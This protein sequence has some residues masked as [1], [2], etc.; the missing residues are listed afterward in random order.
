MAFQIANNTSFID[1]S[2][3]NTNLDGTGT[4]TEFFQA[5]GTYGSVISSVR[6]QSAGAV[7]QGMVRIFIKNGV[8]GTWKLLKEVQIGQVPNNDPPY[9]VFGITL[10]TNLSLKN[11]YRLG[12]STQNAEHF[13]VTGFGYDITGFI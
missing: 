5:S 4:I 2:T 13:I 7:T 6:I 10:Q 11:D 12:A 1:I 8:A 9:P 3:A